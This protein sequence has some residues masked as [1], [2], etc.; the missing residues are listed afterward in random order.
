MSELRWD[1]IRGEWVATATARMNRPQ[2]PTGHCPFCPGSGVVPDK[3]DVHIYP[4]DFPTF[5]TPAPPMDIKGDGFF[6]TRESWGACEVVLY[7]S[8]HNKNFVDIKTSHLEKL[9]DLWQSRYIELSK[10]RR[11]KYV[12]IFE[13]NGETIGVTMPHPH[14]QI[15]AF[16]MIPPIV[17]KE[18]NNS[19][20]YFRKTRN[21]LHCDILAQELNNKDRVVLEDE[22]F[23]AFLPFYARWP[24]ELHLY[25]KKHIGN[26]AHFDHKHKISLVKMI[27][28]I[29]RTYENHFG[30]RPGYMM[31]MHQAPLGTGSE[32]HYH[33]H[34]EFYPINRSTTKLKYRAGCE[35]GA[36]T[37]INDSVPEEK[38]AELKK[39]AA[40]I[41]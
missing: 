9:A 27:K 3:Y 31:V 12:F 15:Y 25:T 7:H 1:P 6:R 38:A 41:A 26:I 10:Q 30:F 23:V 5:A 8:D 11:V 21:C 35:T 29:L 24:F 22:R 34:V 13:N 28:A 19:R 18:I 40:K 4:N 36:G 32:K 17:A 2:M 16:P 39:A 37:F 20:A 14:G 33:F